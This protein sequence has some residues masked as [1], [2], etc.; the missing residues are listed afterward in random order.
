M[1]RLQPRAPGD[2]LGRDGGSV[3]AAVRFAVWTAAAAVV[4]FV[5]AALWVSTC[6]VASDLDTAACGVPQRM[7]L[8]LGTPLILLVG[9]LYAFVRTYRVWREDGI[10][11][12]WQGAGWFLLTAMLLTLTLG[13]PALA[14][15]ALGN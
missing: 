7:V 4:F 13:F 6:G 8:G 5:V 12:G 11:W 9:A 3:G 1:R 14:G 2:H 15:P 10:W